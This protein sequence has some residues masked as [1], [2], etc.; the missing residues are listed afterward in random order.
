MKLRIEVEPYRRRLRTP[1]VTSRGKLVERQGFFVRLVD[2]DGHVGTGEAAPV[3]WIDDDSLEAVGACLSPLHGK[4]VDAD[5]LASIDDVQAAMSAVTI[6]AP[7]CER[8]PSAHAALEAA[9]LD[10]AARRRGVATATIL[11]GTAGTPV[12]VNALVSAPKPADVARE[13][14]R[15]IEG[16]FRTVKLKVGACDPATDG[17]R[18]RSAGTAARGSARLRLDAN[19]A[20]PFDVAEEMLAAAAAASIDYIEEPLARP[21]LGELARLRSTSGV[22][23]AVDESLDAL[24]GIDA[25]AGAEACDVVVLKPTRAGGLLRTLA[26]ARAAHG[27]GLRCVLTD[28]IE[29]KTGRAAVVHAAAVLPGAPEAVGLGGRGLLDDEPPRTCVRPTGPGMTV[30]GAQAGVHP[31]G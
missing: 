8:C 24:G 25:L 31:P 2:G 17:D 29:T 11:G 5:A 7:A 23:V 27:R 19:R 6:Q 22:A 15:F 18:I 10:L 13:V 26:L 16:G 9:A 20:W 28:A 4:L 1:F 21:S 12:E 30:D 3:Y 14:R